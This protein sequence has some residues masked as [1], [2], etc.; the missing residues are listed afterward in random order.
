MKQLKYIF[1]FLLGLVGCQE[2]DEFLFNDVARVQMEDN[3]VLAFSFVYM[4]SSVTR[5]TIKVPI[6]VIGG[7][8]ERSRKVR[9]SQITEYEVVYERDKNGYIVDSVVTEIANKAIPGVHYVAFDDAEMIDL[10]RVKAGEV[11]ADLSVILLRDTS[12]KR[13]EVRLG[14]K[15][16]I[17]DDFQLGE[18]DYWSRTVVIS[19]Q[20]VKPSRWDIMFDFW[21]GSYSV[22]RHRFMIDVLQMP[23]DNEWLSGNIGNILYMRDKCAKALDAFNKDPENLASGKAPLREDPENPNSKVLKF[24]TIR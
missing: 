16:E 13:K 2:A 6:R 22:T 21:L 5:D 3:S 24:P 17:S 8:S 10:Q 19:D 1:V 23:I 11:K 7:P 20:L 15:V 14:V 12:L 4:S 18:K 9:L